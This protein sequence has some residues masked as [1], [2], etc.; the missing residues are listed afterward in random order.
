MSSRRSGNGKKGAGG[1]AAWRTCK[2]GTFAGTSRAQFDDEF[3]IGRYHFLGAS[4]T[5]KLEEFTQLVSPSIRT[6][7]NIRG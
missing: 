7:L 3:Y 5:S 6:L 4:L 2:E 1:C